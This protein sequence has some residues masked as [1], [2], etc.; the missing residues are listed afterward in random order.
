[1]KYSSFPKMITLVIAF[2][3]IFSFSSC[4]LLGAD[5]QKQMTELQKKATELIMKIQ[6]ESNPAK[7]ESL[8]KDLETVQKSLGE[9]VKKMAAEGKKV[10]LKG[11]FDNLQK[12][13]DKATNPPANP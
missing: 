6:A 13:L 12:G 10:D 1:M 4:F 9:L 7:Q 8:K 2:T 3:L 5:A 11:L